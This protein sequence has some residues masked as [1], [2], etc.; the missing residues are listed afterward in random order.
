[1][2]FILSLTGKIVAHFSG[3]VKH[4]FQKFHARIVAPKARLA[5]L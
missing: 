2:L 1:M 4:Y 5:P 3:K